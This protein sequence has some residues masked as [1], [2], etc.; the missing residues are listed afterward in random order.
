MFEI[1]SVTY[2]Q[3]VHLNLHHNRQVLMNSTHLRKSSQNRSQIFG[4]SITD[5]KLL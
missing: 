1:L 5:I 2:I 3:E 4:L